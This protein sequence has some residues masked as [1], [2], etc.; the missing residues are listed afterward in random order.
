MP[1]GTEVGLGPTGVLPGLRNIFQ[2]AVRGRDSRADLENGEDDS[3]S[4]ETPLS[5]LTTTLNQTLGLHDESPALALFLGK[6]PIRREIKVADEDVDIEGATD[7]L[8][9]RR[10]RMPFAH[11]HSSLFFLPVPEP[12]NTEKSND[13]PLPVED[14]RLPSVGFPFTISHQMLILNAQVI[15]QTTVSANSRFHLVSR[16]VITDRSLWI[17]AGLL[18]LHLPPSTAK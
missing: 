14:Q 1:S 16:I 4:T 2:M 13:E 15:K 7:M 3:P 8:S 11:R 18:S 17:P 9:S 6:D 12:Q 10:W 5:T